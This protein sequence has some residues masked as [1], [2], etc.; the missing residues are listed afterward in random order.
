MTPVMAAPDP[1]LQAFRRQQKRERVVVLI[2][3]LT[4]LALGWWA[5]TSPGGIVGAVLVL[6]VVTGLV[7]AV[8]IRAHQC[9]RCHGF[10]GVS[11]AINATHLNACRHCGIQFRGQS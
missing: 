1:I 4:M 2:S 6:G 10:L 8:R 9:P 7:I 11:A 3:L 5:A